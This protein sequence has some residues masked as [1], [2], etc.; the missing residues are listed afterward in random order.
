[1]RTATLGWCGRAAAVALLFSCVCAAQPAAPVERPAVK[2]GDRWTYRRFDY[3]AN[4]PRGSY[5]L[6]VVLVE[7]GLILVVGTQKGKEGESDTTFTADWNAVTTSGRVFNPHT[8]WFRFPL[9]VGATYGAKFDVMFPKKEGAEARNERT[10]KVVGWE[11][12]VVPAGRFRALKIV[13]EGTFQRLDNPSAFGTSRNVI[14][15][16]PEIRRWAKFTLENRP[17]GRGKGE[18]SGEEL[19]EYHLQ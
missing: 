7:R 15:Y 6:R 10:V 2:I 12:V 13:A 11:E 3:D 16:V 9:Q 18:H 5:E 19:V 14:W 17:K 1:M 8:G 4:Q